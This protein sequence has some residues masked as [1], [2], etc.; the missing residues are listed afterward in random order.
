MVVGPFG[1]GHRFHVLFQGLSD[2]A[3]RH[4]DEKGAPP[5]IA[6]RVAVRF[7]GEVE[8]DLFSRPVNRLGGRPGV[9]NARQ[10][11]EGQGGLN[12]QKPSQGPG[13]VTDVIDE[14]GDLLPF[15]LPLEGRGAADPFRLG[16]IFGFLLRR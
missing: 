8:Q 2:L 7:H 13:I 1:M 11:G 14:D 6:V 5:G 10:D 9:G 3:G 4:G 12:G 15:D 16:G